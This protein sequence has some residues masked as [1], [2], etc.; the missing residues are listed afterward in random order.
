MP[1]SESFDFSHDFLSKEVFFDASYSFREK[2]I[3]DYFW[4]FGDGN[5]ATGQNVWHIF[6]SVGS[7]M[8]TL[9]VTDLDFK[10]YRIS[11]EIVIDDDQH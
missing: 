1:A 8:V 3:S 9:T 6:E 5:T 4:D 11:Q 2:I 7:Y 10:T